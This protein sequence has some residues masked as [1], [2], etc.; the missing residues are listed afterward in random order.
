[1]SSG[2]AFNVS[3]GQEREWA[4]L[5]T[6]YELQQSVGPGQLVSL[7]ELFK[8]LEPDAKR[9]RGN[10][11][12]ALK[13]REL[14]HVNEMMAWDTWSGLMLPAGVEV[15]ES[16]RQRRSDSGQR[17]MLARDAVLQWLYARNADGIASPVLSV[18]AMGSFRRYYGVAFPARDIV[19]ASRWLKDLGYLRGSA[20]WGAGVLRP[21]I[22]TTGERVVESGRSVNEQDPDRSGFS[23]NVSG[24]GNTIAIASHSPGAQQSISLSSEDRSRVRDIAD[25]LE[26]MTPLLGL[27]ED[28]KVEA[29]QVAGQL[30]ELAERPDTDNATVKTAIES[31]KATLYTSAGTGARKALLALVD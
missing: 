26:Q 21:S 31:L 20:S 2:S 8:D 11:L 13:A 6:V 19:E 24:D 18:D 23:M 25:A 4:I 7:A 17:R 14:V 16:L 28:G 10:E 1:M 15:V 12:R 9:A 29:Q 27:D 22:T 3:A 5:D 30:R